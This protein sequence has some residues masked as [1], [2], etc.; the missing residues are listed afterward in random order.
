VLVDNSVLGVGRGPALLA[1]VIG[2]AL[3]FT[4][5]GL[6]AVRLPLPEVAEIVGAV[7]SR[8]GGGNGGGSATPAPE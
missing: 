8:T 3:F 2:G 4:V 5:V 1:L 6:L 7:R